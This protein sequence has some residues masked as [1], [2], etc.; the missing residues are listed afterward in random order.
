MK[1]AQGSRSIVSCEHLVAGG[2]ETVAEFFKQKK[3]VF[4]R[5]DALCQATVPPT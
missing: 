1:L 3:L 2:F 4:D 5:Q